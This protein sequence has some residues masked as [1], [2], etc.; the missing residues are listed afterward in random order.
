MFY[1]CNSLHFNARKT[2][3]I[4]F[5]PTTRASHN[6]IL[7]KMTIKSPF[8]NIWII[9][10]SSIQSLTSGIFTKWTCNVTYILCFMFIESMYCGKFVFINC[11]KNVTFLLAGR[12]A[13]TKKMSCLWSSGRTKLLRNQCA[14]CHLQREPFANFSVKIILLCEWEQCCWSIVT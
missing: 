4:V 2:A 11:S 10:S 12:A 8:F 1:C 6:R 5:L 13:T 3:A 9:T 7:I 14:S